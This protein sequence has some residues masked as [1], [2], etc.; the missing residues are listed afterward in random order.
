MMKRALF[1]SVIFFLVLATSA[2]SVE[3]IIDYGNTTTT[4]STTLTS[5][6]TTTTSTDGGS[7]GGSPGGSTP[8]FIPESPNPLLTYVASTSESSVYQHESSRVKLKIK[9]E[10][11]VNLTNI[12]IEVLD[13]Q[14]E[15]F[16]I[17]T[18]HIEVMVPNESRVVT[19]N[20]VINE[21]GFYP[22]FINVSSEETYQKINMSLYVKEVTPEAV[23]KQKEEMKKEEEIREAEER[24]NIGIKPL[25]II[26]GIIAPIIIASYMILFILV[27]RCPICGTKM[28]EIYEGKDWVV[29]KCPYCGKF[30]SKKRQSPL[31]EITNPKKDK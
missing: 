1:I 16:T 14:P 24:F 9:N 6:T 4:T 21:T 11:N 15:W 30:E 2:L 19:I 12:N 20:I 31:E 22:Y 18:E 29:Y 13:L 17:N 7:P 8:G 27:K 10:G 25:L 26:T 23:E 5:T 3:I 28:K